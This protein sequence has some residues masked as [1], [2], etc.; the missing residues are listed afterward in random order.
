M[1]LAG[2][3]ARLPT[4]VPRGA[5]PKRPLVPMPHTLSEMTGPLLGEERVGELDADLTR[6]HAG[7]PLGERIIV[8]GRVLDGDGRPVREHAGRDLAGQRRRPLPPHG[9][10]HP[11]PLDPNFTGGGPLP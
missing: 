9:D 10:Q 4:T 3:T 7:E 1:T 11:A 6:Q 5:R 2:S 8:T